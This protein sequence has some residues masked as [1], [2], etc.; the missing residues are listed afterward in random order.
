MSTN[1]LK[2]LTE[3]QKEL[4]LASWHITELEAQLATYSRELAESQQA[5]K[6]AELSQR[7]MEAAIRKTDDAIIV[8]DAPPG[9]IPRILFV[10][11]SFSRVTGYEPDEAIGKDLTLLQQADI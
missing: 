1:I 3:T 5:R 4:A 7:L 6:A 8:T 9:A 11:D 2:I 10:N